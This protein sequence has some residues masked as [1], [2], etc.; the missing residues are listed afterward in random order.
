MISKHNNKIYSK[1]TCQKFLPKF[2]L[3][4]FVKFSNDEINDMFKFKVK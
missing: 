1:R 3:H 2:I 4:G